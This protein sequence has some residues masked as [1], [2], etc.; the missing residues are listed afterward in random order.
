MA[1]ITSTHP[2]CP[3]LDTTRTGV[4][5]VRDAALGGKDNYAIDR[6]LL[7]ELEYAAPGFRDLVRAER[8]WHIR[9]VRYL[10]ASGF[11]Q[12]LDCGVGLPAPI[13]NTHEIAQRH[14]PE[15]RVV[16]A[17]ADCIVVAHGRALLQE[18]DRVLIVQAD[19]TYPEEL[20]PAADTLLDFTRPVAVLLT[21]TL[22]H[23]DDD[24]HPDKLMAT[25]RD[26]LAPGSAVAVSH[27]YDPGTGTGT[28]PGH[29]AARALE[30]AWQTR[31]PRSGR[32]RTRAEIDALFTGLRLLPPGLV[33]FDDWWP[34]GPAMATPTPTRRL[35]LAG[36]ATKSCAG[37]R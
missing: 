16:Y 13:D 36:I 24:A 10:A 21:D 37:G 6:E 2:W 30:A 7:A 12:F 5:R 26:A 14:D 8:A 20:L 25:Y 34:D 29:D 9:A 32:Y 31:C 35:G 23:I 33:A 11:D 1:H 3:S 22:H 18:N 28:G 4:A 19:Y 17:D 15:A 27:W